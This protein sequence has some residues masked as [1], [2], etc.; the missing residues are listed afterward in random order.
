MVLGERGEGATHL[1]CNF[2][3]QRA[4]SP[5]CD[6][7]GQPCRRQHLHVGDGQAKS[8]ECELADRFK[9]LVLGGEVRRRESLQRVNYALALPQT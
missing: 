8:G 4:A 3:Q 7:R 6:V 9:D 5:K 1:G 2:S